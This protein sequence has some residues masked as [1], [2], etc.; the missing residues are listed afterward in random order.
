MTLTRK[1]PRFSK[2]HAAG[3]RASVF[4]ATPISTDS[5]ALHN[6]TPKSSSPANNDLAY[7][8]W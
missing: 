4:D 6:F 7:Y 8:Y 1:M 3:L 2:L 5:A